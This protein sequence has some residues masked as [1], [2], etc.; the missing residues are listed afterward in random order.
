MTISNKPNWHRLFFYFAAAWLLAAF[1]PA[2]RNPAPRPRAPEPAWAQAHRINARQAAAELRR[3]PAARPQVLQIGF[4]VL[5]QGGHIP[6]AIFAGPARSARGRARLR[7][8]VKNWSRTKRILIY[9]GCCPF[10]MC[11]NIRPAWRVLARM[12]FHRLQVL[13]LPH[14]FYKDWVQAGLPVRR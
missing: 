4:R 9:C 3:P 8:L 1:A 2:H 10:K 7:R 13:E 6:G 14:S 5:Y 12:G 11:P